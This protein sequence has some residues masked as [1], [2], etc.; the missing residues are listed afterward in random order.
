MRKRNIA[1]SVWT[2]RSGSRQ[3]RMQ[4]ASASVSPS[5]RSAARSSIG[6]P[7]DEIEPPAKSAVTFLR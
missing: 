2:T 7:S 6:P 3:S 4:P 1:G 5:R